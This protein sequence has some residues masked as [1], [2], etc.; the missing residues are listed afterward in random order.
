M[1]VDLEAPLRGLGRNIGALRL[2]L[3]D[4]RKRNFVATIYRLQNDNVNFFFFLSLDADAR[5]DDQATQELAC[6]RN[7]RTR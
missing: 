7:P 3:H 2:D 1:N 5:L 6:K 4:A